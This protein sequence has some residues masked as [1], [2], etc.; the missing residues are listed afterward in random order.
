MTA[1]WGIRTHKIAYWISKW[2]SDEGRN[3]KLTTQVITT[4]RPSNIDLEGQ[5]QESRSC[6]LVLWVWNRVWKPIWKRIDDSTRFIYSAD[7]CNSVRFFGKVHASGCFL[8]EKARGF[9][10]SMLSSAQMLSSGS[11]GTK[12]ANFGWN[13]PFSAISSHFQTWQHRFSKSSCF[14]C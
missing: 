6:T 4:T 11:L 2:R 9:R 3:W 7:Y 5:L 8:A 12:I 14:F 1:E 13:Q 10:K